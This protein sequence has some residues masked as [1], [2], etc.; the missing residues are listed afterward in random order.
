MALEVPVKSPD[1]L[2]I[3][4]LRVRK[5]RRVMKAGRGGAKQRGCIG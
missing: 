1:S 2:C 4:V 5:V 3:V